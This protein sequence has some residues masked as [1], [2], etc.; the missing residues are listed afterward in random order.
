VKIHKTPI[1]DAWFIELEPFLDDRG[2]FTEVFVQRKLEAQGIQFDVRMANLAGSDRAGTLRGMHWQAEPFPQA[3]V[4]YAASGKFF[5]AIVDI[6]ET[7]A[8][9]GRTFWAELV[10]QVNALYIPRGVAH[11]C[12]A[13]EDASRLLYFIDGI[14]KPSHE[15][16]IRYDDPDAGIPWPLP[17]TMVAEK[18]LRWPSL[19]WHRATMR[20][21][22][23]IHG[24]KGVCICERD[25]DGR[26][27]KCMETASVYV[28]EVVEGLVRSQKHL[29]SRIKHHPPICEACSKENG[30]F[31]LAKFARGFTDP[32]E[33]VL[34]AEDAEYL[35][36]MLNAIEGMR[37]QTEQL[38]GVRHWPLLE[39]ELQEIKERM[40]RGF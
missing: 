24:G 9:F 3:K 25:Q 17:A 39:K 18:D 32:N 20:S 31:I 36:L 38:T 2:A 16:G 28:G 21:E 33:G 27:P 37:R 23:K 22:R 8:T 26:C 5:D 6:R 34:K 40:A 4:V 15:L 10:P 7:S 12:Q 35:P 29:Q 1:R 30:D 14:Y 13:L 11:G 19:V